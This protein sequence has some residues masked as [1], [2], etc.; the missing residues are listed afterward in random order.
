M[1]V[2]SM[3]GFARAQ[4]AGQTLAWVFE[5][6]S[7]NGR[8]LDLRFRLPVPLD[9][10]EADL[11]ARAQKRLVRGNVQIGV[12][13]KRESIAA[14]ARVN[15]SAFQ[16]YAELG[17]RLAAGAGLAP[18]TTG[19]IMRLPGVIETAETGET[20]LSEAEQAEVAASFEV[21]LDQLIAARRQEG[22]AL[23]AIIGGLLDQMSDRIAAAEAADG[24]RLASIRERL[25]TQIKALL[26]T[27]ALDADRLHQEAVLIA[28]RIDVREEIDRLKAHVEQARGHLRAKD[29]V[30]RK[31]DFLSQEFVREANTLCSK[32]NDIALTR[33]GLDL[34]A[35]V[36][37]FREQVQNIE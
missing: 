22:Q 26:E 29:A 12:S 13:V 21:A 1:S 6:R 36:E 34:K 14:T 11:R 37:Q 28:S 7:V 9:A 16:G 4:G 2:S 18:L 23:A 15:D 20:S 31:L 8:G 30:G 35:I 10:C 24:A 33:I 25:Q 27:S 19:D 32:A 3:T 17:A 5:L